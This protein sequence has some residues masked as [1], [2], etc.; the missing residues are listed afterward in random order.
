MNAGAYK[1]DMSKVVESV[2]VLTPDLKIKYLTNEELNY[3]YRDSFLKQ[4]KDYIV[5]ETTMHLSSGNTIDML[6]S[7][8]EKRIK[9]QTTQPLDMPSAGSTFRNPE[10][11]FAGALIEN[12][13]LKGFNIGGAEVSKKHANFIVNNGNATGENIVSLIEKIKKE[14]K[15][16]YHIDLILEQIIIK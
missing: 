13:N 6:E 14:V 5:L 16:N 15:D 4:N 9:R 3:S 1:E 2:K 11:E 7:I 10:N 8:K 12:L